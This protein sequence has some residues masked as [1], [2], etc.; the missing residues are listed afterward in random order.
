MNQFE[1]D[2][3]EVLDYE[4]TYQY[5]TTPTE[6]SNLSEL[7]AIRVR[8]CSNYTIKKFIL[9]SLVILA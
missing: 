2:V 7:F 1:W 6:N 8:S 4:R 5:V 9:L 3:A